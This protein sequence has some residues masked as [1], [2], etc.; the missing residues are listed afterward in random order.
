[1]TRRILLFVVACALA[2]FGG[3]VGSILGHAIGP[4]GLL[5]GAIVGGILGS[6]SAAAVARARGWIAA[7]RFTATALGASGGFLAAA[8]IATHT[9]GSP[10]G[11]I[12][13]T[14]L[15]GLGAVLGAGRYRD[16]VG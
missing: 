11:P 10:V 5:V 4:K 14:L 13:S 16:N 6:V 1:M 9:L 8:A 3:V 7:D 2:G 12:L 15:V